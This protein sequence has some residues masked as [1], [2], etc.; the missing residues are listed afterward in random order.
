MARKLSLDEQRWQGR[1]AART[2]AEAERIK[3]DPVLS[4]LAAKESANILKEHQDNALAMAKVANSLK[5]SKRKATSK[6]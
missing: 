5:P 4:K 1:D 3:G 6:K 2:L